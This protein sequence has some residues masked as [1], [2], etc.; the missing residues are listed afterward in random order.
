MLDN[1]DIII[2]FDDYSKKSNRLSLYFI[3]I[4]PNNYLQTALM[5]FSYNLINSCVNTI[6]SSYL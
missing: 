1:L 3:K 5:F 6:S 2:T 4:A